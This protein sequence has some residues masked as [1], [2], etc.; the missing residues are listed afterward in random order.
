MELSWLKFNAFQYV[1]VHAY[2]G[3]SSSVR[4]GA[5]NFVK[6]LEEE[7]GD[8]RKWGENIFILMTLSKIQ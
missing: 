5:L 6:L 7:W 1:K 3:T 2:Q 8:S 4:E